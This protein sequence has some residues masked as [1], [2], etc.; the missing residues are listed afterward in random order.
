M[1]WESKF[2]PC[3]SQDTSRHPSSGGDVCVIDLD[4]FFE[5]PPI[6]TLGSPTFARPVRA[7][8]AVDPVFDPVSLTVTG[9]PNAKFAEGT[10]VFALSS[11]ALDHPSAA[12]PGSAALP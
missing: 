5:P 8:G 6:S 9:K 4:G 12:P 1:Y 11:A 7:S 2:E 3:N 10:S